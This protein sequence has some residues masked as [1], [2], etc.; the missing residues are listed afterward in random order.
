MKENCPMFVND[1]ISK[2]TWPTPLPT[3]APTFEP[4]YNSGGSGNSGGG[5]DFVNNGGGG[6][7]YQPTYIVSPG[8]TNVDLVQKAEQEQTVVQYS[9]QQAPTNCEFACGSQ[10]VTGCWCDEHCFVNKDCC[11]NMQSSC[12]D[13]K[14]P[15]PGTP[16]T[17]KYQPP[18]AQNMGPPDYSHL[19][20]ACNGLCGKKSSKSNGDA[21]YCDDKCHANYDCCP[22]K[23]EYCGKQ[24]P[25]N[26]FKPQ[27]GAWGSNSITAFSVAAA[28]VKKPSYVP[29]WMFGQPSYSTKYGYQQSSHFSN[30]KQQDFNKDPTGLTCQG[31]CGYWS[32][33]RSDLSINCFCD[34]TCTIVQDCCSDYAIS[35]T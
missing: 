31:H 18:P 4:E 21:C 14:L 26:T 25:G 5:N 33:S 7:S 34:P 1:L 15:P 10:A 9:N 3:P 11:F 8:D 16:R 13:W 35:C 24:Q 28:M 22:D 29:G 6:G 17:V 30:F 23:V 27:L 20:T 12:P 19:Y 32:V 2:G